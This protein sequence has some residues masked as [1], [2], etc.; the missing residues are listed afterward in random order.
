MKVLPLAACAPVLVVTLL[1]GV[2]LGTPFR[3]PGTA[4][5]LV[6]QPAT[7]PH[8]PPVTAANLD[9]RPMKLPQDFAG[10]RNLVLIAFQRQQQKDVDTWLREIKQF[11]AVDSALRYYELPTMAGVNA[12]TRWLIDNGMRSGIHG[13]EREHIITLYLDKTPFRAALGLPDESRIYVLLLDSQGNVVWRTEGIFD[14]TKA[15]SLKG[16]LLHLNAPR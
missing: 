1:V 4:P 8:F 12:L 14:E 7:Q 5:E 16:I 2:G 6:K 11:E 9:K 13:R 10:K 15:N 3:Y